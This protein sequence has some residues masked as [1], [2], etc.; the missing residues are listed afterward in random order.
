MMK[1]GKVLDDIPLQ[2]N[3]DKIIKELRLTR[4]EGASTNARKLM[5]EAESLIR[6]RA[7]YR[8]SY[9]DKKGKDT[10]EISGITFSSRVLRINL[11][12]VERVFSYIITIGKELEDKASKS[13]DLLK[14][15]YL[16]TIG[17]MALYS[18]MQHLEKH[19]KSQYGLDKLANMN[20]GSLED[21]PITE[22]KLLFS[23]FQDMEG[24]IGVKLTENMLMIPRKSISGIYFPTEVNF[25]SCQL[26][27]RE[28]CQA[29]KAPYDKSLREKYRLDDE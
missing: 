21:W 16:E 25:F 15:F 24:Q 7:V 28:R 13:D 1:M 27:P 4:K 26:C 11:E 23:L 6:A 29:R 5:E 12:K 3:L 17:D 22:Q 9:I 18:S 19:L 14:Q 2:L 8:V 20:P 10:V